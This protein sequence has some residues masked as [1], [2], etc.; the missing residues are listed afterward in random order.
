MP[1]SWMEARWGILRTVE[2]LT[3]LLLSINKRYKSH[4]VGI[5]ITG[6]PPPNH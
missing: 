2:A 4:S 5:R 3:A 6:L 1:V